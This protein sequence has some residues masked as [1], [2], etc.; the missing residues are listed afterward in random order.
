MSRS[1]SK[2]RRTIHN[3]PTGPSGAGKGRRGGGEKK[4]RGGLKMGLVAVV[5]RGCQVVWCGEVLCGTRRCSTSATLAGLKFGSNSG[6]IRPCSAQ[7]WPSPGQIQRSPGQKWPKLTD[8][9]P[10]NM[11]RI[12][13]KLGRCQAR[14]GRGC[15]V[16]NQVGPSLGKLRPKVVGIGAMLWSMSGEVVPT[17]SESSVPMVGVGGQA[18][19]RIRR[20]SLARP[21]R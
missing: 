9:G 15:S 1:H 7:C 14:F 13:P 8:S 2:L 4:A 20:P 21:A 10:P 11:G 3:E 12:W 6:W 19:W 18:F 16:S 17:T 5:T